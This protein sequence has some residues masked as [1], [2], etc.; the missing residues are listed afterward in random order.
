MSVWKICTTCREYREHYAKGQCKNCYYRKYHREYR[1]AHKK[2]PNTESPCYLGCNIAERILSKVFNNVEVMEP[3]N[4]GYDFICNKGKKIDVKSRCRGRSPRNHNRWSFNLNK[5][6][7]ADFFLCI[8][9]DDRKSLTPL[10]LWL[11]P[12]NEVK[13]QKRL[14]IRENT[15]HRL[16]KFKLDISKTLQC[17]DEIRN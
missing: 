13:G 10:Y 16:D 4:P 14:S 12:S 5:N 2:P 6:T 9:F 17:C 7:I 11:I 15:I 3:N 8:A 1:R